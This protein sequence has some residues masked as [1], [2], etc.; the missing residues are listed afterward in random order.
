MFWLVTWQTMQNIKVIEYLWVDLKVSKDYIL[1]KLVH[2]I[3]DNQE[4][5]LDYRDAIDQSALISI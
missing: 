3:I 5:V 1:P 2:I 4:N